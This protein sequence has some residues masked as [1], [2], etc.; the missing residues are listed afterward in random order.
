VAHRYDVSGVP[1]QGGYVAKQCPVRAQWDAIRPCDPAPPSPVLERRLARGKQ[2]EAEVV[3]R[4]RAL[5]PDLHV[6]EPGSQAVRAEREAA[7]LSAMR[8]GVP[9]IVGPRLPADAAGRRV[10]EPDLLIAAAGGGY[11][12]ADVKHHRTLEAGPTGLP[13]LCSPF[14]RPQRE[15]AEL[16]ADWSAR[17]RREDLLQLA[18]YQ[19]M[20]EA[21]GLAAVD[22]RHGGIFGVDGVVTW[23]DLDAPSWV[24]PSSSGRRK[25]RSTIEVYD[26]EFG[27]RLDILAVAARHQ[28]DPAVGLAVVPVRIAECAECPWWSWCGPRLRAGSG[29]VSLLPRLGWRAWR[30]HRDHGVTD[31][32][33]LASLDHRTATLVAS[34]VDLRPLLA[35]VGTRPD[36]T[37]AATV[38]GEQKRARLRRL[39][40]AGV[41]TLGEARSLCPRTAAYSDE[42]LTALPDQIDLAR[43]ALGPLPAYR[44]RGVRRV[45][46]PR[47][48]VEVDI[49]LEN[50]E[51]G[52][53]LWGT[54]VTNRSGRDGPQSSY[55]PF[56]TWEPMTAAVE[57]ALFGEFWKW[58]AELRAATAAAGLTFRAYCYNASAEGT[59]LRRLAAE[60]G[61]D[62]EVAEF[63]ASAD[64]VDLL[65][66]FD[67]QLITGESAGLKWVAPLCGF[68]WD[69][70]DPGGGESMLRYDE[71]V[72]A[73]GGE[74]ARAARDWLL[75]YNRCDVEATLALREWL[76]G[77]A[78]ACPSVA[79]L[80]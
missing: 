12:P 2:F 73:D 21:G 43:A 22:G 1:P 70:D 11:R 68:S 32:A 58:L 17:K 33:A 36:D 29:D 63:T 40:A 61:L 52:V 49:D 26:F 76:D 10:G 62:D 38:I 67:R 78:G 47:G 24:T 5:H 15:A 46:V 48:Q 25:R 13:A 20:L 16:R 55:R 39:S 30:I 75:A 23:Y 14:E 53:Y 31:R 37:P 45:T 60:L 3:A 79:D 28:A 59:Q 77:A 41:S 69:V 65:R 71:A 57:T 18:H 34:G 9:L 50:T 7:T 64:W 6:I 51:A 74:H 54:L 66:V 4:L 56:V 35:A 80:G 72:G 8:A 42:P 27:F 44:R 19:R